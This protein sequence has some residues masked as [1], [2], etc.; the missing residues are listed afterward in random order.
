MIPHV[1]AFVTYDRIID[2]RQCDNDDAKKLKF[3]STQPRTFLARLEA[4]PHPALTPEVKQR[5]A[6][7]ESASLNGYENLGFFAASV[8]AA[9][10][11]LIVVHANEGQSYASELY[12][13]NANSVGY[14]LTRTLYNLVYIRGASGRKRGV[15]FYSSFGCA[16]ALFI[17]A[18]NALRKLVK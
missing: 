12:W 8:V 18:G 1:Y 15:W 5:L 6:R 11:A 4:N 3:Q 13:V 14:L 2:T 16:C 7:S 17:H 10:I 9:N